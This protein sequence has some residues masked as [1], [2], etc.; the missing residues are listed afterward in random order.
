MDKQ[1]IFHGIALFTNL[2]SNNQNKFFNV[3]NFGSGPLKYNSKVY[4][5]LYTIAWGYQTQE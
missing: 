1:K 3:I 2:I 5:S 4:A